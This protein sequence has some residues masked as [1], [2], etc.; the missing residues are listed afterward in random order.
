ML[1]GVSSVCSEQG[2]F[3]NFAVPKK[4][5]QDITEVNIKSA[6]F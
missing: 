4:Q 2:N 6:I 3:L 5:Q 1:P